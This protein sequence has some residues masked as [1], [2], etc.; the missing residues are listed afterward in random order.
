MRLDFF[1]DELEHIRLFDPISQRSTGRIESAQLSPVSEIILNSESL[2]RF[3]N[4]YRQTFGADAAKDHIYQS[5]GGGEILCWYG[6][7]AS[8]IS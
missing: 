8:V 7:L 6:A 4:G 3:K 1:G 5:I 2:T